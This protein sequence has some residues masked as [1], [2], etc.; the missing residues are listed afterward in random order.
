MKNGKKRTERG[1]LRKLAE[2]QLLT[3]SPAETSSPVAGPDTTAMVHELRVHQTELEMQNE[4]LRSAQQDLE[5]SRDKYFEL[6][7]F[8]PVGYFTL[9]QADCIVGVNLTGAAM[10]GVERSRLLTRHF[11]TFLSPE[12]LPVFGD[13]CG[14][15][16]TESGR[17]TCELKLFSRSQAAIWVLAECNAPQAESFPRTQSRIAL[18]DITERKRAEEELRLA[19][20]SLQALS[21]CDEILVRARDE[22]TLLQEICRIIVERCGYRLAWVGYAEDSGEK[23]VRPVAQAGRAKAYVGGAKITW[24]GD[25]RSEGPTGTAIRTR[26]PC[27]VRNILSDPRFEPWRSDA[28]RNGFASSIALPLIVDGVVIGAMNIYAEEPDAFN[29]TETRFLTDLADDLAFGIV[30][31]RARADRDRAEAELKK[32]HDQLEAK[33][34]ER[35]AELETANRELRDIDDRLRTLVENSFEGIVFHDNGV[36]VQVNSRF[37]EM[38]GRTAD[39][40][41][42]VNVNEFIVPS[43]QG[44]VAHNVENSVEDAYEI[45]LI[46]KD[47]TRFPAEILAR[48][49][50]WQG[51][52][53]RAAAVRD[54]SDRRKAEEELRGKNAEL[55]GIFTAIPDVFFRLAEDG[56]ILDFHAGDKRDLYVPTEGLRGRRLYEVLPPD[57]GERLAESVKSVQRRRNIVNLEYSLTFYGETRFFDARICPLPKGEVMILARNITERK[58]A[59]ATLAY[60]AS[61]LAHVHDA[62]LAF[63]TSYRIT[64]WNKTAE[65]VYGW[66]E[67][68]ALGQNVLDLLKIELGDAERI[69]TIATIERFEHHHFDMVQRRK[70]GD[71]IIVEATAIALRDSQG[72][73]TGY[74]IAN[75]D[76]TLRR[77][78][79]ELLQASEER[80]RDVFEQSSLGICLVDF[81]SIVFEVNPAAERLLGY[82]RD[83]LLGRSLADI[84]HPDD[85][86]TSVELMK[87]VRAGQRPHFTIEKRYIRKGGDIIYTRLTV[88]A[89]HTPHGQVQHTVGMLEDITD[90]KI[91]EEALRLSEERLKL[92]TEAAQVGLWDWDV[93]NNIATYSPT[94]YT[95]LGYEPYELP[96]N[97][98]TWEKLLHPDDAKASYDK[99]VEAWKPGSGDYESECRMLAKSGEY[100]WIL[101]RGR[102]IKRDKDGNALRMMGTHTDITALKQ[103]EST[104]KHQA[105]VL[106][107]IHDAVLAVDQNFQITSWNH[108]AEEIYGWTA[109]EVMGR[110]VRTVLQSSNLA[111]DNEEAFRIAGSTGRYH[112]EVIHRCKD[113]HVIWVESETIPL[114]DE[115]GALAGYAA[116]NRDVTE[117]KAA[118]DT[119]LYHARILA[120]V[121]DAIVA[122]DTSFAVNMWNKAAEEIYGWTE[123]EALGRDFRQLV[124]SELAEEQR[125]DS[126]TEL[127]DTGR[128]HEETLHHRRDGEPVWIGATTIVL[129]DETGNITGYVSANRDITRRRE[130]E[131][132]LQQQAALLDLANDSITVR[133]FDDR[134]LFW[135]QGAE[136]M[137]GWKQ[138]ETLDGVLPTILKTEYPVPLA[139]I[140]MTLLRHH[141]YECDLIQTRRDGRKIEVESR[142]ALSRDENG[143]PVAIMQINRDITPRK[144]Y[145]NQLREQ[146]MLIELSD[147]AVIVR[148]MHDK[149]TFWSRGAA[150]MY[151]WPAYEASDRCIHELLQT[152]FPISKDDAVRRVLDQ[153]RWEG[154][155]VHKTRD[156]RTIVTL[157]RWVLRSDDKGRPSA[158]LEINT[159]ITGRKQ[160]EEALRDS[161]ERYRKLVEASPVPMSMASA[162][163]IVFVNPAMLRMCGATNADQLIGRSPGDLT[164]PDDHEVMWKTMAGVESGGGTSPAVEFRLV[165]MDKQ[166]RNV[167]VVALP[168]QH[169]NQRAVQAVFRDI[170][171][172]RIAQNQIR[173]HEEELER[174]VEERTAQVRNLE[175][176]RTETEK[177]VATGRMAARIA[178]E[179]NNPLAGV[180][181][182]FAL[183]K[184]SIPTDHKHYEFVG[185]IER[186]IDRIARIVRQMYELYRPDHQ[187]P[188]QIKVSDVIFDIAALL[189]PNARMNGVTL[190]LDTGRAK[191]IVTLSEDSLRQ[192]IYNTVQNAI[193]A[194]SEGEHVKLTAVVDKRSLV[195][196]VVDQG[197]G[198]PEE[199]RTRIFEPFFTTKSGLTT[200]GLGLGLSISKG[201][202]EAMGGTLSFES[203]PGHGT[204]FTAVLPLNATPPENTHA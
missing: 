156:G 118:Q 54:L 1:D 174:L 24:G 199:V 12:S 18:T 190:D 84:S 126:I 83:E 161:E 134:I 82:P 36:V 124:Q 148:D 180:K 70:D 129:K 48:H 4:E 40:M 179:I 196:S 175:R 164:H 102:V 111:G 104:L 8:A 167:E 197:P 77:Q 105:N 147:D 153:G 106:A 59:E 95:L 149:I 176:Q 181:N 141:H 43:Y 72:L 89:V 165:R 183:V 34:R 159:D 56:S 121:H 21:E 2:D 166:L 91:A 69:E 138:E 6:Y 32:A 27:S 168:F 143:K 66:T 61:V 200:G 68:E 157:S 115:F 15:M 60:Q 16:K 22:N 99:A 195:F 35:T 170:T 33:V 46:R 109:D 96:M 178:H 142:W 79:E 182:S 203:S 186:E 92:G 103:A 120:N 135:N 145:E 100:R 107:S 73:V 39:E 49:T 185:R 173:M 17:H 88:F 188:S 11:R 74:V 193:E 127:R 13:F 14:R 133:D 110:D 123:D 90:R 7:D 132:R 71:R 119:L 169:Q 94:W 65:E 51:R 136:A 150:T 194:S 42:G 204:T 30:A 139:E 47:G 163:R 140:K 113:G 37:A 98:E 177:L 198:I 122:Y 78:A 171:E 189:E 101:S 45:V 192:V 112:G 23:I 19:N 116:A 3:S 55:Q 187:A 131:R 44:L 80:F 85:L 31:I 137:Y 108:A 117:R 64:S 97:T 154:E 172:Q 128:Y 151:G 184:R 57:V 9:D 75:R 158:I 26:K 41:V 29:E 50:T 28:I 152:I 62:I 162:G 93:Q 20:R 155:L 144:V 63:D 125:L 130:Y 87:Q 160:A 86:P 67:R 58:D 81:N 5:Q 53:V 38:I 146:A 10:L 201:L 25:E 191:T 76:I 202:V 114:H 52:R